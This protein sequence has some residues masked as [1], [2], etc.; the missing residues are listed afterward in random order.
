MS[1]PG[2]CPRKMRTN[3]RR[4]LEKNE[5]RAELSMCAVEKV[6]E[7]DYSTHFA[8]YGIRWGNYKKDVFSRKLELVIDMI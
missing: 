6:N 4:A 7:D 8:L 1:P 3:L 5:T 2:G